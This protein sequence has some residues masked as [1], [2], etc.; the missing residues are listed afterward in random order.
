MFPEE[1][2]LI[3]VAAGAGQEASN[4]LT[5]NQQPNQDML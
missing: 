1:I 3:I 4:L 2:D 5:Q